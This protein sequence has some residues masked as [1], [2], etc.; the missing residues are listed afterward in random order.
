MIAQAGNKV[1]VLEQHWIPGGCCHTFNS[2]GY[3]F[4]TGIHYV[5]DMKNGRIMK[6]VMD[7]LTLED[8][9]VI[10][11][12]LE[13]PFETTIL[14]A[15]SSKYEKF[16][17]FNE[18][19]KVLLEKFPL[20]LEAIEGYF[21]A[22][23][24]ARHA[25]K[26]SYYIKSFPLPI[27]QALTWSGLHKLLDGGY[28]KW[29]SRSLQQVLE[30]L[31]KN[32]E[33]QAVLSANYIDTG[34]DPKHTPFILHAA[35]VS[36]YRHGAF[37]PHGG[38]S[39]I[40]SKILRCL[41]VN[42]GKVLVSAKVKRIILDEKH[43]ATGVELIDG[44]AI[45]AKIVV[46]DAG[47]VNTATHLLPSGLVN[48]A[49]D[50]DGGAD[51]SN[52]TKES[53]HPS[54]TCLSLFVGFQ[55]DAKT[56]NLPRGV[57]I[58]H[59]SNEFAA[60]QEH[61]SKLSLAEALENDTIQEVMVGEANHLGPIFVSFPSQNDKSWATD[62][63]GKSVMEILCVVPWA[64]FEPFE[65]PRPIEDDG[66]SHQKIYEKIKLRL[67]DKLWQ[68]VVEVLEPTCPTLPK[69]LEGLDH[70]RI[71]TP[72]TMSHFL[73]SEHGALYGLDHDM[74]RFEPKMHYLRLRPRVPEVP[75]LYLSG[76]DVSA[77]GFNGAMMGG[78]MCAS[79]VLHIDDPFTLI[80]EK[81]E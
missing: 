60:N 22:V 42:G 73:S 19:K 11:D 16:S 76:Q 45:H 31:T 63:P 81:R 7:S 6:Q 56:L 48:I 49:I 18:Y 74:K 29:A 38:P 78:L 17:D 43:N 28:S 36:D 59:P 35:L 39:E 79:K 51:G 67:A 14:G 3:R 33:L 5:G 77:A 40:P 75:G 27:S 62:Y 47:L 34:T 61:L 70:F 30:E 69:G 32:T 64:W 13:E 25:F 68:R 37:Y 80:R 15:P 50:E 2:G 10:W 57:V 44:S 41:S 24:E 52:K 4:G 21:K 53:L 1:L 26:R 55:E 46:S 65:W 8:D 20:E 23:K 54:Q 12:K 72:L 71:G 66:K 58:I 9:P